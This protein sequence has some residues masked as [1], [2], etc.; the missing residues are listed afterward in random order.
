MEAEFQHR[1]T[2]DSK[3][4]MQ[5]ILRMTGSVLLITTQIQRYLIASGTYFLKT[6]NYNYCKN[7]SNP[8]H[9]KESWQQTLPYACLNYGVSSSAV[10][11]MYTGAPG[12]QGKG[13]GTRIS[14]SS[15][16]F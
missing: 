15:N 13:A 12:R 7:Q 16:V 6:S 5:N 9:R 2:Y 4:I 11:N 8:G 1:Q 10:R 14:R 3:K